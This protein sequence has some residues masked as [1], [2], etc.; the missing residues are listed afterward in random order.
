[1]VP[2]YTKIP[3]TLIRANAI[4]LPGIFLSQPPTAIT[5]SICW[6]WT[7]TSI[8]SAMTSRDTSEYFIPSVPMPI[9]G[10][11][12]ETEDLRHCSSFPDGLH[13]AVDR[14]YAKGLQ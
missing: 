8:E 1:M 6:P 5:P 7:A 14:L 12:R 11:G 4:T 3:G 9:I 10:H 2:A 13:H